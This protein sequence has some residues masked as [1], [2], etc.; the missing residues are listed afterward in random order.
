MI[1]INKNKTCKF[2]I[3]INQT[4]WEITPPINPK[5]AKTTINL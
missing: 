1:K 5:I 4:K 2:T 3:E